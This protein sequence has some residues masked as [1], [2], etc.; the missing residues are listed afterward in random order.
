MLKEEGTVEFDDDE[1]TR[2]Q[3]GKVSGQLSRVSIAIMGS[4]LVLAS[5]TLG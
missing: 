5:L 4:L 1:D 2:P 3:L